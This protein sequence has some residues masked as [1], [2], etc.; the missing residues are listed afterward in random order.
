MGSVLGDYYHIFSFACLNFKNYLVGLSLNFPR[1]EL[2]NAINVLS[3]ADVPLSLFL[4]SFF[5][6]CCL[7]S[8]IYVSSL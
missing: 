7:L 8:S 3:T 4:K 2:L 5:F 6:C 1:C